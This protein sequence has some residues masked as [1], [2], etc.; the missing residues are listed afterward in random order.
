MMGTAD[1]LCDGKLVMVH[2]GGHSESDVPFFSQTI[3]EM[4]AELL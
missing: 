2:E 4:K 3:N 1:D